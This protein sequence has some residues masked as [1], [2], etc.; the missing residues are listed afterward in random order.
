M[1]TKKTM[2]AIALIAVMAVGLFAQQQ[3]DLETDFEVKKEDNGI[4]ITGYLGAKKEVRIPP[5]IQELPVTI[6]GEEAFYNKAEITRVVLPN[7]VIKI[8]INAFTDCNN[9]AGINI[10]ESVKYISSYAFLY[11]GIT[12]ITIPKNVTY[13]GGGAFGGCTRLSAINVSSENPN[14]SSMGG[15]LYNKSRTFLHTYPAG[16]TDSSNFI[17][18]GTLLSIGDYAFV[19]CSRIVS[20]GIPASVKE[21]G[22]G[23]FLL[24][25][26]L[27][28][29]TVAADNTAYLTEN[30]VLYNKDK[31]FL[32]TY[33]AG[34]TGASFSIP[35]SVKSIGT[36][37]F[38]ACYNLKSITFESTI[39]Y[40]KFEYDAFRE[41][42]DLRDKF[43]E[44]DKTNGTL[45]TYTREGKVWT[46]KTEE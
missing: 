22:I 8:G 4:M 29:L 11:S 9:L 3:Y 44:T 18:P 26:R 41:L 45:G 34:R 35:A 21:I 28:K 33:P 32:H 15:V 39:P 38:A 1:N 40:R 46:M 42:G 36:M 20:I 5:V 19:G 37:A 13:I 27:S 12:V 31:T 10:P 14:Y 2:F 7:S 30:N 24:C 25:D 23:A 6:I 16:K 43:Y 17:I